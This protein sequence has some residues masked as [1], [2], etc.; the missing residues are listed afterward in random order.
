MAKLVCFGDGAREKVFA[1][2]TVLSTQR[3]VTDGSPPLSTSTDQTTDWAAQTSFDCVSQQ[4]QPQWSQPG[5]P[6]SLA[7][8]TEKDRRQGMA[9]RPSEVHPPNCS[10]SKSSAPLN[11]PA[12]EMEPR[13]AMATNVWHQIARIWDRF[14]FGLQLFQTLISLTVVLILYRIDGD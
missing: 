1:D 13:H 14:F 7:E 9:R 4:S 10:R 12:T 8:E 5:T 6:Q 3:N 2:T 11:N